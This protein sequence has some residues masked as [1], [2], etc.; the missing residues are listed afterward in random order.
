M[1]AGE[2]LYTE[3]ITRT[4]GQLSD[5]ANIV[6][7]ISSIIPFNLIVLFIGKYLRMCTH[8]LA[9]WRLRRSSKLTCDILVD[10]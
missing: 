2:T 1:V 10:F 3:D 9:V 8:A 5:G 6:P 7:I 4:A